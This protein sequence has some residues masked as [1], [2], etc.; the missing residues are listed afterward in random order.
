VYTCRANARQKRK[1]VVD[2][3]R[4]RSRTG[5]SRLHLG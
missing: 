2:I 3:N 5:G 1:Y 4:Q